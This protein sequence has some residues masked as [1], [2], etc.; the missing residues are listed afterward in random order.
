[1]TKR[2]FVRWSVQVEREYDR[3]VRLML[4]AKHI[5][6]AEYVRRLVIQDLGGERNEQ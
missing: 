5:S 6:L 2:D 3:R 4:L 1:M